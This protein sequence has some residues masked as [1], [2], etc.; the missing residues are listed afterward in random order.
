MRQLQA[1]RKRL[2]D[3]AKSDLPLEQLQAQIDEIAHEVYQVV[4]EELVP[5]GQPATA[6]VTTST[7]VVDGTTTTVPESTSTSVPDSTTTA[8]TT[9]T[10]A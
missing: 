6:S 9:T 8:P 4:S 3:L 7:T 5:R 2:K 1:L 10:T